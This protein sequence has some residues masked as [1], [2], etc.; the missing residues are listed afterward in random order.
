MVVENIAILLVF[1]CFM[2][3]LILRLRYQDD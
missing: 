2:G 1:V 3:Y